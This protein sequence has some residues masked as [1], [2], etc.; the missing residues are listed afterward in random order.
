MVDMLQRNERSADAHLDYVRHLALSRYEIVVR[1]CMA[2]LPLFL[3]IALQALDTV[4]RSCRGLANCP[5]DPTEGLLS[6][7]SALITATSSIVSAVPLPIFECRLMFSS[8]FYCLSA[9]VPIV[10][11]SKIL[12]LDAVLMLN[13]FLFK[14]FFRTKNRLLQLYVL[15][16]HS[17]LLIRNVQDGARVLMH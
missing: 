10:L 1:T 11:L 9:I 17:Q 8:I 14:K 13:M 7:R 2:F 15:P 5:C 3:E 6:L 12:P 4:L 16:R